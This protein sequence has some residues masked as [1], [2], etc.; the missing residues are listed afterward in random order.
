MEL[1]K[2]LVFV[3]G[4]IALIGCIVLF[5]DKFHWFGTLFG[6]FIYE[7]KNMKIYA[8]LSSMLIISLI[9][10]LIISILTKIFK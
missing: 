10:S 4:T 8:P 3:G 1:G 7:S 2:S 9:L 6:D 5:T